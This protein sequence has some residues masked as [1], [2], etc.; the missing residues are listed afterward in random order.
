[1]N[2]GKLDRKIELLKPSTGTDDGFTT[3]PGG[4]APQGTR[5]ARYTPAMS[6]ELFE[7]AGREGKTPTVFEV[8]HDSL[9][10]QIDETWRLSFEGTQYE[11]KGVQQLGRKEGLRIEAVS[12]DNPS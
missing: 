3:S 1:M 11:I 2:A 7:N 8:R 12:S 5:K 6:R 4:L 9:T 10:D